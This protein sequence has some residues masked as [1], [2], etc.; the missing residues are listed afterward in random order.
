MKLKYYSL[1]ENEACFKYMKAKVLLGIAV[2]MAFMYSFTVLYIG[3]TADEYVFACMHFNI[4]FKGLS[5]NN[6]NM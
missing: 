3:T 5:E 4:H 6:Q 1:I 2:Y